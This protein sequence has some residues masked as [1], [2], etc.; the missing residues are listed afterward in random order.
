MHT[1]MHNYLL[2]LLLL[3][4]IQNTECSTIKWYIPA[5]VTYISQLILIFLI[6]V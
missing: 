2:L 5:C 3:S 6:Y 1:Y 4:I